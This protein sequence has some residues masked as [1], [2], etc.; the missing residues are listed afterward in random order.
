MIME[1]KIQ[2]QIELIEKSINW[3]KE[4]D[5]MKG[6]KGNKAYRNLVDLRR[7]LKKKRFALDSNPA[8]AM[9]GESQSGKS[10]L[11]SSL[12]SEKG[13]EF[14]ISYG[15]GER[16]SFKNE[17]NPHG[18]EHESTSVVTRFSVKE[19]F[20]NQD[21]PVIAKLLSP[22]DIIL[23]LC[24]AYYSNLKAKQSLSFKDLQTKI[25]EIENHYK[26]KNEVQNWILEDDVLDI[27]EYF[28]QNFSNVT[29]HNIVDANF[30]EKISKIVTRIVP[31][32]WKNV[33]SLLWNFNPQI[34]KLFSDLISQY[35]HLNFADTIYLPIEAVLRDKGTLLD[36]DRLDEIYNSYEGPNTNYCAETQVFFMDNN[37][38]KTITFSKSYICALTGELIFVLPE[39][40]IQNKKFLDKTDLLDFPGTRRPESTDEE[41][42][43]NKS[44]TQ[45]LRRGRVDYLFNKY[46]F[47]EKI[48]ILMLCQNHKDSKQ[49]VMPAK[50]DKWVRKMV[51]ET[52]EERENFNCP[53]P[54]L[55]VIST[56]FNCDLQFD[57]KHTPE[58]K[59]LLN[60]KWHDRFI[61]VLEEQILK[62][63]TYPWFNNWTKSKPYFQ[64]IYLLR[65]FEKSS[66]TGLN[67][68]QLFK[69]YIEYKEEKEEI[70][71]DVYPN[72]RKDL[73]ESFLEYDFVQHHFE[74]P[75]E[76]WDKASS[77]NEDGSLLIIQK[78]TIA[79]DSINPARLKK[80]RTEI[81][82][83]SNSILEEL[84]KYYYSGD[85]DKE[86]QK[87]KVTAGNI[88]L[89]LDTAFRADG[90][91]RFGQLM[92]ELMLDESSVIEL[93]RKIIDN[94][95]HRDIVNMDI[96]S[97]YRIQVPVVENETKESYFE[98][99]CTHYE[100][101][102]E[103]Q[104]KQFQNELESKK[105][106]LEELISGNSDLIKNN[107]QQLAEALIEY[108]FGYITLKDKQ[109]VQQ[110]FVTEDSPALQDLSEMFQKLFKK[111][112]LSKRI[113]EKIRRYV[114]GHEKTGLPYEMV[115]DISTELLNVCIN[116]VGFDYLD[117]SEILDLKLA[118]EKNELGLVLDQ[119][120]NIKDKS[121]ADLF[122]KIDNWTDIIQS[123]P[124]E[125]KTLPS[126][127]NY[128]AWY[129]RLKV[130]FIS[131]CNIPNYDTV[132]NEKLGYLIK[133]CKAINN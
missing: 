74:N 56:W 48:N 10:Y 126:Y 75:T 81:N 47:N 52:I 53:I 29:F 91:K 6:D 49:S 122:Y 67:C 37:S 18:N 118:N 89:L 30:F 95:E 65:D 112:D 31:D 55:F 116:T 13:G 41:N 20:I 51:G 100:K 28:S 127:A 132:A 92:K 46:S 17:I 44:L 109:T 88:Q 96:Y 63:D 43:T 60:Q 117:E 58:N 105:I 50:V 25:Q 102:T 121:V 38:D 97:T 71:P 5:S 128:I 79:S 85:K 22:T 69:G 83:I 14:E 86:L 101:T 15:R 40:I 45:L 2:S 4:T 131:V 36:V 94:I 82:N 66:N 72:F 27:E 99:L 39:N 110:I 7:K 103:E 80:M 34:T 123:K 24:E 33:F 23:I 9:F 87:A 90:I 32:E 59:D 129:N 19:E 98:R 11:V 73:R 125:M 42:I 3:V 64:N 54:P 16:Y 35:K 108:W 61:K 68:S 133:E 113:A 26:E 114:D 111:L 130:S 124:E 115:A 62:T 70:K 93:Y 8:V 21:F 84:R 57:I 120:L 76:S 1:Q 78:L 104:K 107:A 77:I 119:E 12:L 106:D